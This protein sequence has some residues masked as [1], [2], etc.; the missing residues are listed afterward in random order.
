MIYIYIYR[1]E[2]IDRYRYTVDAYR[3]IEIEDI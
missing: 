3:K 1:N 2:K